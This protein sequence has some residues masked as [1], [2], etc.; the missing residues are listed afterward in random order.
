MPVA[1]RP[2][3]P[4]PSPPSSKKAKLGQDCHRHPALYGILPLGNALGRTSI[5]PTSLG[6]LSRLPHE[7]LLHILSLLPAPSLLTFSAISKGAFAFASYE[8][9]WKD[10][11]VERAQGRL[12]GWRGSWRKSYISRFGHVPEG[13]TDWPSDDVSCSGVFSDILY[14]PQ[15]CASLPLAHY[16][17]P[18]RHNIP[19]HAVSFLSRE[20]FARLYA[21][22]NEPV[23]LT[24]ALDT[25][26][27]YSD[28]SKRW[29]LDSL[30]ARF[31][32]ATF[33]AEA[34]ACTLSEYAKYARD[35][36]GEDAPLYLF[37]SAFVESTRGELG[38]E[39]RVADVFGEDLF[40]VF[41]E[42]RPNY[43]WLIIGPARSGS[44]FHKDPNSTSAWNAAVQGTKGWVMFP[45]SV[46][47][48]GVYVSADEGEV[49]SPM[50]LAEWFEGYFVEAW[51]RFGLG[52][53]GEERGKMRVGVQREGDMVY[54]PSGWWHLVVN[55]SPSIAVTQNFVSRHELASVLTFMRDK[56]AQ[57]S[58][59]KAPPELS[60]SACMDLDQ[61]D[62]VD[63]YRAGLY[64]R[65][66]GLLREK[67]PALL[68]E[69]RERMSPRREENVRKTENREAAKR[70]EDEV[71]ATKGSAF[72]FDFDLDLDEE[73]QGE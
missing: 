20:E 69:A 35:C 52:G 57:I 44:T 24:G 62:E 1:T 58:G 21:A 61:E 54:V 18:K 41:G 60:A 6:I 65:F 34:L 33:Q 5:L 73:D 70:R 66:V 38:E 12:Q 39:Y 53:K 25:W 26:S 68:E 32:D 64:E 71:V 50:S 72:S 22:P 43:R 56:P 7:L 49:T 48:P 14:Q 10:H 40:S 17:S 37:D 42:E 27:G 29:T 4:S 51:R 47:P 19:R 36:A 13:M 45:P 15:L 23:I 8:A 11:Y 59:F 31:P 30:A 55:L 67:E 2:R 46:L 3:S 28:P 16:F 63:P 9:I